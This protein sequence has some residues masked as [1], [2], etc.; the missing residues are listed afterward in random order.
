MSIVRI[1]AI[2][3]PDGMGEVLEQRFAAR[4]GAVDQAEGFEGFELL[5]PTGEAES[6]YFAVTHWRSVEDFEAW[7]SSDD[8]GRG[9]SGA[10]APAGE[11]PE[12][13]PAGHGSGDA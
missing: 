2:E 12:A 8:F 6:R 10:N 9:H 1:N 3:V 5:R 4:L 11:G 13:A 7:V